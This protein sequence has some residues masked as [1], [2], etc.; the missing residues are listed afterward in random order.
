MSVFLYQQLGLGGIEDQVVVLTPH[1]KPLHLARVCG[2]IN[3]DYSCVVSKLDDDVVGVDG[4]AVVGVETVVGSSAHSP[5][6]S[7]F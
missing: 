5:V 2:L 3:S 6:G 1:R 4:G 7:R